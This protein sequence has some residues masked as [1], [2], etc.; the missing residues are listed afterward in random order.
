MVIQGVLEVKKK[1][2]I[3]LLNQRRMSLVAP[4][5]DPHPAGVFH[6]HYFMYY[7]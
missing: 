6:M 5:P 2:E 3:S 7:P 1:V 4:R